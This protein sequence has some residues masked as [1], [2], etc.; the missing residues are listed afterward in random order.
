[1]LDNSIDN[2]AQGLDNPRR[3]CARELD[4]PFWKICVLE[5]DNFN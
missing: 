4:S 5:L 2:D 1:M 3:N